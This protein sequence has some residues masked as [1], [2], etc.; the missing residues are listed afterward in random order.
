MLQCF[1]CGAQMHFLCGACKC[2][3][4]TMPDSDELQPLELAEISVGR[5][6]KQKSGDQMK[7]VLSTG[8]KR[9]AVLYAIQPGQLCDW[10][11]QKGCG[12]GIVPIIGCS[13]RPT[14]NI[15]H[16][17]DKSTINNRPDNISSICAYCHNLWHAKNDPFYGEERIAEGKPWLPNK[18]GV[19]HTLSERELCDPI[20]VMDQEIDLNRPKADMEALKKAMAEWKSSQA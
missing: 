14:T 5:G 19:I 16:G 18:G 20:E 11:W 10:R 2:C 6:A 4:G 9:A 8:R 7:D 15:H 13:G 12:G 17:P 3:D 1:Y